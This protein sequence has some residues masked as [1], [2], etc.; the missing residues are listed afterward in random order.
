[1]VSF[2]VNSEYT[3]CLEIENRLKEKWKLRDAMVIPAIDQDMIDKNLGVAGSQYLEMNLK[4]NDNL[5]ALGWGNTISL[6][7]ENLTLSVHQKISLVSLAGG[8]TTCFQQVHKQ[9]ARHFYRLNKRFHMIPAPLLAST[10]EVARIIL[11]EIEVSRI[12]RLAEEANIAMVGIGPMSFRSSFVTFGFITPPDIEVIRKQGG[13]GDIVGQYFDR[14][15]RP[16][17]I[18]LCN[19]LITIKLAQLKHMRFVVGLAGGDHKVEAI[20][21]ALRGGYLHALITDERTAAK[22]LEKE[23]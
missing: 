22:L 11:D 7:L 20:K 14:E 1:M 6:L 23:S 15:G 3:N 13:I 18:E 5:V 10:P 19:R 9:D 12:F 2:H 4:S 21:G 8:I 17:D 16:M